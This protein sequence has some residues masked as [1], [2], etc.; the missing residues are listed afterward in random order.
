MI[1]ILPMEDKER[2][3]ALLSEIEQAESSSRVLAMCEQKQLLGYA[4]VTVKDGKLLL[5]KLWAK[6]Y[7]FSQKPQGEASF[8]LD[9]L[10]RAAASYGETKGAQE[11]LTAF[12]D[13]W[14]FF[15]S[16]GFDADEAHAFTPMDTIVHYQ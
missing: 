8:I 4:A 1:E 13:F 16:R 10:M 3:K 9:S 14:G 2:E 15:K 7:D 12:P 5:L 11:I 6:G